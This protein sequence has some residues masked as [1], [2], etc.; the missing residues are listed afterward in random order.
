VKVSKASSLR[1]LSDSELVKQFREAT[2]QNVP[3]TEIN[4]IKTINHLDD[5]TSAIYKE[6]RSRGRESQNALLPLLEDDDINV[7]GAA[8]SRVVDFE[9]N[10][11]IPVLKAV[12][13]T[14]LGRAAAS[15]A[16]VALVRWEQK[17]AV[18]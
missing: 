2:L 16:R 7:R 8:A 4:D 9:P 14:P 6:L 11:A 15:L 1:E 17:Q 18:S 13:S 12:E 3:A 10:R 5:Y